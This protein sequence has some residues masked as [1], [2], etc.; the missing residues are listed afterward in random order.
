MLLYLLYL[1][2]EEREADLLE[3]SICCR[4]EFLPPAHVHECWGSRP[5]RGTQQQAGGPVPAPAEPSVLS[6]AATGASGTGGGK[7]R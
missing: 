1:A 6:Q 7:T 5:A 4:A 3:N 2:R